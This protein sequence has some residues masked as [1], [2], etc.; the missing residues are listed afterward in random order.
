MTEV[1]I[2]SPD[3]AAA[4]ERYR[5]DK[6]KSV[7]EAAATDDPMIV[8]LFLIVAGYIEGEPTLARPRDN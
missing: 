1:Q 6:G 2:L 4:A 8:E 7:E 5:Q 3:I